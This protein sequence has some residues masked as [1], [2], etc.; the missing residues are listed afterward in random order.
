MVDLDR[1]RLALDCNRAERME[2]HVGYGTIACSLVTEHRCLELLGC[3]HEP[4]REIDHIADH[5]VLLT[6]RT[7]NVTAIHLARSHTDR[8]R[9]ATCCEASVY[10][11]GCQYSSRT[12]VAM[13]EWRYAKCCNQYCSLHC[14][15]TSHLSITQTTSERESARACMWAIIIVSSTLSSTKNCRTMPS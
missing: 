4:C 13:R 6:L 14:S 3:T 15:Y 11:H 8:T 10:R 2:Q 1:L 9:N 12:I 5:G 7:T